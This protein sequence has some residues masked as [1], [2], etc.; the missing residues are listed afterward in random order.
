MHYA[1]C[2]VVCCECVC[3]CEVEEW[4]LVTLKNFG[5]KKL[6]GRDSLSLHTQGSELIYCN[7]TTYYMKC[8]L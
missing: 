8:K 4:D 1:M 7:Y 3:V 2:Y 6:F 5:G